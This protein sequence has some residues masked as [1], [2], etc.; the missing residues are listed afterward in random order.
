MPSFGNGEWL[1]TNQAITRKQLRNFVV[2]I[3]FWDY[4]CVNCLRTLPYLTKWHRRYAQYGLK[5]IGVHSPEFKFAQY[6][7]N[8]EN[9][10]TQYQ[11]EYPILLDNAYETW[12]HFAN[13]AWPTKYLVDADGYVRLKRQGEGYYQE[14]ERGIQALLRQR[15]PDMLLPE[16][17]PPLRAEDEPGAVCFRPTPELYAGY[18][19]GGLFG[20][21]LGNPEG[22]LPQSPVLYE[23][24]EADLRQEGHFYVDGIWRAWPEALAFA[25]QEGGQ[26][27]LPYAA[28]SVNGVFAPTADPVETVLNWRPTEAPPLIT[29]QQDGRFL[30][31]EN[32]G[33]DVLIQEDGT[34]LIQIDHPRMFQLV[35]NP[36]HETHEL[37]LIFL[38]SGLA[39]YAFSFTGCVAPPDSASDRTFRVH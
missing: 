39:L 24:P 13:K 2:L 10:L 38:A 7:S 19:G 29:V 31:P 11:I 12:S 20:G 9:A 16:L 36:H 3:D 1:N 37:T 23:L 32:A 21:A 22:Y 6:P 35:N 34:S 33:K 27:V 15:N 28:A 4:T 14:F 5:I 18:Q 17:L 8:L 26:I 30:T 25:G